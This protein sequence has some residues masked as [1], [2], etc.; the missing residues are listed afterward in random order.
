M[1]NII[2][3]EGKKRFD[4]RYPAQT[5]PDYAQ[6]YEVG[7]HRLRTGQL[8][9]SNKGEEEHYWK[10]IKAN[11]SNVPGLDPTFPPL[12]EPRSFIHFDGLTKEQMLKAK[13]ERKKE[14][15]VKRVALYCYTC[16][17]VKEFWSSPGATFCPDCGNKWKQPSTN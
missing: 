10:M 17:D 5:D 8:K 6:D 9:F 15:A 13:I 7:Q 12:A 2:I 16:E 3:R 4:P 1:P 11:P 14:K